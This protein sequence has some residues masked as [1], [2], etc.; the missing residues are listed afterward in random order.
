MTSP[1]APRST[2]PTGSSAYRV[3][4]DGLRGYAIA[5][6]VIFHVFV[7]R[8]SGGVDV[9]LFLSG[10]FFLGGQLRYAMR[11]F[12]SLN[13]WW[14][15]WRTVRRLVPALVVVLGATLIG[16]LA[17]T[18]E[19]LNEEL[20]RQFTASLLYFQNWELT[21]QNAAYAAASDTTSPLQHLWSMSVQGQFY[22][23]GI[24]FATLI[25]W[26]VSTAK[27]SKANAQRWAVAVLG[28]ITVASFAYASRFGF[29][30]TPAN[31]YS[32]FS[33]A[34]EL[35]LGAL[36]AFV[37]RDWYLPQRGSWVAALTGVVMITA[38]GIIIPTSLAFPGPLALL[39]ITGAALVILAGNANPVSTMLASKPMTW[40]G[41]IAYSLY[42][43]HWPLLI[44]VTASGGFETPPPAIGVA[45]ILASLALA[46]VTHAL[47]EQP[48]RQHRKRP[49]SFDTPV[50]DARAAL[51]TPAGAGRAVGG[52]IV[53]VLFACGLAV[54]PVWDARIN[55]AD[56]PLDP[57]KYPGA[58]ALI[59]AEVPKAKPQPNPHLI[60]GIY[61]PI[62]EQECMIFLPAPPDEMPRP[63]CTFGDL[64]AETTVVMV[65]GSHIEPFGIPLDILGKEHGFKVVP[66]V[67]QECPLVIGGVDRFEIVSEV[68]AEWGERV[69]STI[70]EMQPDLVISTSTRPGGRAGAAG[71]AADTVPDA[72]ANL[73]AN[74][75]DAGIPFLGLRDN[76]WFF[77]P[78]GN[79]MDPNLCIVAG[80]TEESC[81]MPAAA[82]Y[83]GPDPA[84]GYLDGMQ[85]LFSIDTAHWYCPGE[86]CPPQI[87]NVYVYRDQNHISNAYAR[88]L[89]QLLWSELVKVFDQ[90][91]VAYRP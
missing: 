91:G 10:Y 7:G 1:Q 55:N 64:D 3:D 43:W 32:T 15:F 54:Q 21:A 68:C 25:A 8:V 51:R 41:G 33:R 90:L 75:A 36:L 31:Y 86:T 72:Y 45:V 46:H 14:P 16:I 76:P 66:F 84:A 12:P 34:W 47:V 78:F 59:D 89:T 30:G 74:F 52:A 38:T 50:V 28:I 70:V 11:P 48:L 20:A 87:G 83:P 42:L 56:K 35:S 22:I 26:L 79:P 71:S 39:P 9:F 44:V 61:P 63:D 17:L 77:D 65:G 23:F 85:N 27:V 88:S 67:R 37:P 58:T 81:S 73:W 57:A 29:E 2:T 24:C 18:P 82:A 5:L 13:P 4:L 6:V 40:L 49:L 62:G 53:A 60:G 80:G 19:L 69:Y